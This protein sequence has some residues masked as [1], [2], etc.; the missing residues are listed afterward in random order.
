M[1]QNSIIN[2]NEPLVPRYP[3]IQTNLVYAFKDGRP[4]TLN[5]ITPLSCQ[6]LR[7][8]FPYSFMFLMLMNT[9]WSRSMNVLRKC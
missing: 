7:L 2:F 9:I 3:K 5:L 6:T 8:I 4:L 1:E